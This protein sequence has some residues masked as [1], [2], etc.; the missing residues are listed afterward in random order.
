M[1]LRVPLLALA[2]AF[3]G[4]SVAFSQAINAGGVKSTITSQCDQNAAR[5]CQSQ[6]HSC[7]DICRHG[8]IARRAAGLMACKR[9][10][11][12]RYDQCKKEAGCR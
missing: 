11:H 10:C 9:G 7:F 2:I 1:N 5:K 3:M 4:P 8:L 12:H 6:V